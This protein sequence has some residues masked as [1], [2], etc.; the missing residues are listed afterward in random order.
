MATTLLQ[1]NAGSLILYIERASDGSALTG[2]TSSTISIDLK[3]AG[4]GSFN[5]MTLIDPAQATADIGSGANGTVTTTVDA[6]GAGGNSYTVEVVVPGGTSGLSASLVGT[7]L[8]VNLA[9]SSGVPTAANTATAIAAAIDAEAG[10]SA[11]A[12][13]TGADTITAAEGPTAFTGGVD[14]NFTELGSG[15]YELDLDASDVDTLGSLVVRW[16]GPTARTGLVSAFVAATAPT[17]PT[18]ITEPVMS[19]IF[20]YIYNASGEPVSNVGVSAR[21]L[22]QPTVL[23]PGSEGLVVSSG[24]VTTT[25]DSDGFFTLNLIAGTSVDVFIPSANYRRTILVPSTSTNLFDI[26]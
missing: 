18:S 3:K 24:L 17:S 13:G 22:S 8:T 9:V 4:S 5:A 19:S 10:V 2:L 16:T 21:V 7:T 20:G 1:N 12:S 25:T 11:V 23:H 15:F 14:G 6:F 26:A